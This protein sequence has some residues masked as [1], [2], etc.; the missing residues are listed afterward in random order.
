AAMLLLDVAVQCGHVANQARIIGLPGSARARRNTAYMTCAFL[1]GSAGSWIGVRAYSEFGWGG[2][3]GLT[4]L[5]S[6][7]A[8]PRHL[9]HR[10]SAG[11]A[12]ASPPREAGAAAVAAGS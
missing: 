12:P 9:A 2:I 5:A 1:G 10:R 8:L 3:A 4:A 7:A 11:A 6:A